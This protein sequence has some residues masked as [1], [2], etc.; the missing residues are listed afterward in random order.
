MAKPVDTE[1]NTIIHPA[2]GKNLGSALE[3]IKS[4]GPVLSFRSAIERRAQD[5]SIRRAAIAFLRLRTDVRRAALVAKEIDERKA[6]MDVLFD[7]RKEVD[8]DNISDTVNSD[9]IT[10][11][12]D[13]SNEAEE[14]D[15]SG[16]V[17]NN[18]GDSVYAVN[19]EDN[20]SFGL[21]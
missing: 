15:N 14:I 3:H 5:K 4:W 11:M 18:E 6:A 12:I 13:S 2:R 21:N 16:E 19:S 9:S 8:D 10:E 7:K 1:Q 20:V 17:K